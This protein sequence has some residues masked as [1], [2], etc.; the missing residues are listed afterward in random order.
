MSWYT[1]V[2]IGII[3]YVAVLPIALWL[4]RGARILE[5]RIRDQERK[6]EHTPN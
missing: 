1:W 3:C 4:M 5:E 6:A 2:A